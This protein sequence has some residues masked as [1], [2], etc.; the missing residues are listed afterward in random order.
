MSPASHQSASSLSQP[1]ALVS[2]LQ[3]ASLWHQHLGHPSCF[4]V[5]QVLNACNLKFS[6]STEQFCTSCQLAKSHR[7]LFSLSS[8]RVVAPFDLV[9]TDVWGPSPLKSINGARYFLLFID[10]C[11]KYTWI[12]LLQSKNDVQSVFKLFKAMIETQ[13]NARLK[14]LQS[15][16]G[17]EFR[18]LA[19]FLSS[20]GIVHRLSCPYTP[21]QNDSAE[22]KN[23][24][25]VEVGLSILAHSSG[26]MRFKQ[27]CFSSIDFQLLC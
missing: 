9:Y 17:T 22:C 1:T 6:S 24:H 2:S 14:V 8:S 23:R 10:D 15:G 5:R 27:L 19:P 20:H 3:N 21:Q 7:L 13:F 4:I 25:V 12:Y 11:T 16:G 26:L 18:A